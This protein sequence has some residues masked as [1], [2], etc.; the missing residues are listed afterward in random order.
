MRDIERETARLK[1]NPSEEKAKPPSAKKNRTTNLTEALPNTTAHQAKGLAPKQNQVS[2]PRHVLPKKKASEAQVARKTATPQSLATIDRPSPASAQPVAV[3]KRVTSKPS[4]FPSPMP[5]IAFASKVAKKTA[6]T[7]HNPGLPQK[8]ASPGPSRDFKP[9]VVSESTVKSGNSIFDVRG[10][11]TIRCPDIESNWDGEDLTLDIF[12]DTY[13]G[14]SH[15]FG[16]FDFRVITGVMRFEKPVPVP[17]KEKT[18]ESS[19]KRKWEADED[20]DISM[21]EID[22]FHDQDHGLEEEYD[23]RVFHE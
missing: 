5:R 2:K 14:K 10:S 20:E 22:Q 19:K 21:A 7:A 4:P 23:K 3:P 6:P 8:T 13:N 18:E 1:E 11:Y 16:I 12:L 9:D 15:L 17:K